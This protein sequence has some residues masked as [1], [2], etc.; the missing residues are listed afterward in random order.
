MATLGEEVAVLK[1]EFITYKEQN[2][3]DHA[4]FVTQSDLEIA[5]MQNRPDYKEMATAVVAAM[6]MPPVERQKDK[7]ERF[8]AVL[9]LLGIVAGSGLMLLIMQKLLHAILPGVF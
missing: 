5:M 3:K 4:K 8:K 2:E 9:N 7:T 1:R 6:G